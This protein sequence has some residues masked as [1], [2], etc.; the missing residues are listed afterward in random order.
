MRY[1]VSKS[2]QWL[3]SSRIT[4]MSDIS[5]MMTQKSGAIVECPSPTQSTFYLLNTHVPSRLCVFGGQDHDW[6]LSLR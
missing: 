3:K 4:K 1:I 6:W 2:K 5:I